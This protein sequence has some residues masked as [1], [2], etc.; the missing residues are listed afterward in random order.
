MSLST[1]LSINYFPGLKEALH[2]FPAKPHSACET[3]ESKPGTCVS[4]DCCLGDFENVRYF[5][6]C[7]KLD[8]HISPLARKRNR[9]L[10]LVSVSRRL[11]SLFFAKDAHALERPASPAMVVWLNLWYSHQVMNFSAISESV[12]LSILL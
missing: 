11:G 7:Q 9:M 8:S 2:V 5:F 10:F 6:G 4:P 3:M 12:K 1:R